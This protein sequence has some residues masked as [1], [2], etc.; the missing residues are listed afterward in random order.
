MIKNRLRIFEAQNANFLRIMKLKRN[1][2][3]LIKKVCNDSKSGL[4]VVWSQNEI[5]PIFNVVPASFLTF[6]PEIHWY[7]WTSNLM[8]FRSQT[9]KITGLN[10]N[11]PIL[12]EADV[13]MKPG[14]YP[15]RRTS[16]INKISWCLGYLCDEADVVE[17]AAL[18]NP[19]NLLKSVSS[20]SVLIKNKARKVK[21]LSIT[22][23]ISRFLDF[24]FKPLEEAH[25]LF[26]IIE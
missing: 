20:S 8:W 10:L 9:Y 13:L 16:L 18:S 12:P 6:V 1:Y 15:K 17:A 7:N 19:C 3:I 21:H 14:M 11:L 26:M 5:V 24:Y 2:L 25:Q 23:S 22:L 4:A